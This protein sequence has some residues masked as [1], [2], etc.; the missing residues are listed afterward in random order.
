MKHQQHLCNTI[1]IPNIQLCHLT[2]VITYTTIQSHSHT[3]ME[4]L[5]FESRS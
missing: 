1:Q 3:Q 2:I 4:E 5:G